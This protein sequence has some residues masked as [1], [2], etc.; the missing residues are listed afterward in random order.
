M[1]TWGYNGQGQ[2][3]NGNNT[4][5]VVVELVIGLDNVIAVDA[6]SYHSIALQS[7]FIV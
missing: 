1:Y 5:G 4:N 6:G 3:G 2:L 7:M